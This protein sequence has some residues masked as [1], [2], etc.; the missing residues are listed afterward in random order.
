MR[1]TVFLCVPSVGLEPTTY[2][3]ASKRSNP[4]SYEGIYLTADILLY[5]QM[6]VKCLTDFAHAS[7]IGNLTR[8]SP[9]GK[10]SAFQA[11]I[12]GFESHLPLLQN[13]PVSGDLVSGCLIR[14]TGTFDT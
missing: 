11:D 2:C 1:K 8:E 6:R 7:K 10:A 3:S 5:Y 13:V 9:S 14:D 4:L 12:R